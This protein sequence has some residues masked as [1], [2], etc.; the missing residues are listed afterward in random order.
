MFLFLL[1]EVCFINKVLPSSFKLLRKL[2]D[3]RVTRKKLISVCILS[4]VSAVPCLQ[5]FYPEGSAMFSL[6]SKIRLKAD[7]IRPLFFPSILFCSINVSN[8]VRNSTQSKYIW[9]KI[10]MYLF[11]IP[12]YVDGSQNAVAAEQNGTKYS[13]ISVS[14][15]LTTELYSFHGRGQ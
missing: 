15:Y 1:W 11:T 12:N 9:Y 5:Q 14:R 13:K 2:H 3:S 6:W 10:H 8:T 4:I 7:S